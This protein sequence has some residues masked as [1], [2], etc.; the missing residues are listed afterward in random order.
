MV[1]YLTI[2]V[3]IMHLEYFGYLLHLLTVV[4]GQEVTKEVTL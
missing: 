4:V 3:I 2:C 1:Y